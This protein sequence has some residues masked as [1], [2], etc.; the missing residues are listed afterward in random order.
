[1]SPSVCEAA[2]QIDAHMVRDL[3]GR[4]NKSSLIP[5]GA[6]KEQVEPTR[7]DL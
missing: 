1:M 3:V 6:D 5:L 2:W 7:S 4:D